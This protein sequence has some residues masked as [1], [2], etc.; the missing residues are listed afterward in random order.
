[1]ERYTLKISHDNGHIEN[2]WSGDDLDK[3]HHCKTN[4]A[5][6]Y[7]KEN[8]GLYDNLQKIKLG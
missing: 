4:V 8:V 1:M 5:A 2:I 6:Y 7:G 3:A